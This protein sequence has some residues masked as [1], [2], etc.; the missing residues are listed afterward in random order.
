MLGM[1]VVAASCR[2]FHFILYK[3]QMII[4]VRYELSGLQL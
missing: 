1:I 4:K 2:R 3:Y